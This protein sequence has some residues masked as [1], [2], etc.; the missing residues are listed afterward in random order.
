MC[1]YGVT[2]VFWCPSMLELASDKNNSTHFLVFV[3]YYMIEVEIII[4]ILIL[5]FY[6]D[7]P[8]PQLPLVFLLLDLSLTLEI[9]CSQTP[10]GTVYILKVHLY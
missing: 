5:L 10:V 8:S 2:H 7:L 1:M 4:I 9:E 3:V 6:F